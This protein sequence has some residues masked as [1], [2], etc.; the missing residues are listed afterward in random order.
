MSE[1]PP[2]VDTVI[3]TA[4]LKDGSV[5]IND[6]DIKGILNDYLDL[7]VKLLMA[8]KPDTGPTPPLL[9][10]F[11]KTGTLTFDGEIY[12]LGGIPL[13][14][15]L[16]T[17]FNCLVS[18]LNMEFEVVPVEQPTPDADSLAEIAKREEKLRS[19]L[20]KF[21]DVLGKISGESQ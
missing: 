10:K 18:I 15:D 5:W 1:T 13:T 20:E 19:V 8:H 7:K 14:F 12:R 4:Y 21:S 17:G 2:I 3:G 11:D 6:R 9:W 16:M